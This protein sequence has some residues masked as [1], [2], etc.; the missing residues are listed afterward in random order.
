MLLP[1]THHSDLSANA[2]LAFPV[3]RV[4]MMLRPV[5][6]FTATTGERVYLAIKVQNVC[7]LRY[8]LDPNANSL[9]T[10]HALQILATMVVHVRTQ[11]KLHTTI[12][13]APPI[14][15]VNDVTS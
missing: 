8:L 14:L 10:V 4:N 1:V 3:L 13:P 5:V 12:V 11:L 6:L 7:A 9:L 2:H 15:L